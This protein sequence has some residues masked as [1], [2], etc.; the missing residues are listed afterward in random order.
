MN[1]R[2]IHLFNPDHEHALAANRA[3]YTPPHAARQLRNDLAFL[4]ALWADDG[5]IVVVDDVNAALNAYRKLKLHRRADVRWTTLDSLRDEL[6]TWQDVRIDPWV[7][8]NRFVR[9]LQR[10]GVPDHL[11]PSA[12]SLDA[13]RDLSNRHTAV[14]I[15]KRLSHIPTLVGCSTTCHSFEEVKNFLA[16]EGDIVVK[17]PWSCSGRGIRYVNATTIDNNTMRWIHNTLHR[18]GSVTVERHL[19]K[20]MDF[21]AEFVA[22][23]DGDMEFIGL[24]LFSTVNG[25]YTGNLLTTPEEKRRMLTQYVGEASLDVAI[26]QTK[27]MLSDRIGGAYAG[28]LGVDM[29]VVADSYEDDQEVKG[30]C[31]IAPCVEIN[32]R[33]TMGHVALALS[34]HSHRGIMSTLFDGK[35]YRLKIAPLNE[36]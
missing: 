16:D 13:I 19:P 35:Q 30:Y 29:M 24:S 31:K 3:D 2:T 4:P 8:D 18:Q 6:T 1:P 22:T 28:P 36:P 15:L 26:S 34:E 11:L 33:R 21:A 32:L 20:V 9:K 7:W 17:A 14:D 25:M 10:A 5:D 27:R 12:D 23:S